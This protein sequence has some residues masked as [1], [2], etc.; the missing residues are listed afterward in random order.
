MAR[1]LLIDDDESSRITLSVLLESDG[2]TVI[3]A[4]SIA[5]AR[6]RIDSDGG[7]TFELAIVD[8]ELP[9]GRGTTLVPR[10]RERCPGA[11]VFVLTGHSPDE[12]DST[13]A[14]R[15]LTKGGDVDALL[16]QVRTR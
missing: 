3:E 14:D 8:H 12:V 7:D 16:E 5:E 13:D 6:A 9:D 15:V 1:V 4:G 11:R 10:F 2:H